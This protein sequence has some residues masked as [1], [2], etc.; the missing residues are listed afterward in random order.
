MLLLS[1]QAHSSDL[2][3][4]FDRM[5][6]DIPSTR[7]ASLPC[8]ALLLV[9]MLVVNTRL[10]THILFKLQVFQIER[11]A[12]ASECVRKLAHKILICRILVVS[13][14]PASMGPYG[15]HVDEK[16]ARGRPLACPRPYDVDDINARSKR[17]DAS[18]RPNL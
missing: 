14:N 11:S 15:I 5:V 18:D 13:K 7:P 17:I 12:S 6:L 4:E 3:I 8:P 1:H 16:L 9:R 2:S 10:A